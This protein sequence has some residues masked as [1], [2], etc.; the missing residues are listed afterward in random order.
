MDRLGWTGAPGCERV[1]ELPGRGSTVVW[2]HAGP[3]GSPTLV[4][5]HGVALTAELN[6]S[7]VIDP[8]SSTYRVIALDHRG[9]GSGLPCRPPFRLEDCADDVDAVLELLGV[10][11]VIAVG[12]S[13]GGSVAQLL[14][15]RHRER[16]AGLVLC[17]SARNVLGSPLERYL[18]LMMP[19]AVAAARYTPLMYP[20]GADVIGAGLLDRDSDPRARHWALAEMRRTP[21][22]TALS[23]VQAACEFSSHEWIGSVDVPTA[24]VV[25]RNDRVVPARRQRKLVDALPACSVHEIDG[26]HGVFLSAPGGFAKVLLRACDA[27]VAG[28]ADYGDTDPRVSAS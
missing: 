9:H 19:F 28:L 5:L 22:V 3:P 23:A 7:R 4:L 18:A 12:Y 11:R 26:D 14:W 27:V 1:L 16:T 17:S 15:R 8:L 25:T 6:W 20:L 2:D 10:D 24:A 13:M 21:L